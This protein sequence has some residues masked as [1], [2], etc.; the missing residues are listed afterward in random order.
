MVPPV[1]KL[2]DSCPVRVPLVEVSS[3][4]LR[5][6]DGSTCGEAGRSLTSDGST[7]GEAGSSN[8]PAVRLRGERFLCRLN[9][10]A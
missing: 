4:R 5:A 6:S 1:E 7:C 3:L 8:N 9:L 10:I 2:A